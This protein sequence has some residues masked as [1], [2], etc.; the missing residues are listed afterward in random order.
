MLYFGFERFI[1]ARPFK[2]VVTITFSY[3]TVF[4]VSAY[5]D[6]ESHFYL[7]CQMRVFQYDI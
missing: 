6:E 3:Y 5:I 7:A 4:K 2:S 1:L